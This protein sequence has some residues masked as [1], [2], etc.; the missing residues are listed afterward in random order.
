MITELTAYLSAN[1]PAAVKTVAEAWDTEPLVDFEDGTDIPAIYVYPGDDDIQ[2]AGYDFRSGA[3]VTQVAHVDIICLSGD[4][5]TLKTQIR[6]ILLGWSEGANFTSLLLSGGQ[7]LGHKKGDIVY[8]H[9]T[10]TNE[11]QIRET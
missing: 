8:W 6:A 10:W 7:N 4:L 1:K 5:E 11:T 2:D 9:D 3:A